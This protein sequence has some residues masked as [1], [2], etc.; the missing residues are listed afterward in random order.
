MTR[1]TEIKK[2]VSSSGVKPAL[3]GR[4]KK[5]RD[6]LISAGMDLLC[7][8]NFA[9]ISIIELTSA[10]GYSVGTFYSRFS[11]KESFFHAA[12]KAAV[13][14]FISA[15][16]EEF[17]KPS[18]QAASTEDIFRTMVDLSIDLLSTNIRGVVRGSI[19][20]AASD[21]DAWEPIRRCG[22]TLT[23]TLLNLLHPRFIQDATAMS[24]ESIKFG[25]QMLFGTLT[26]A[27]L[28]DNV[29]VKLAEPEMRDNLTRMLM[30]YTR[31][32]SE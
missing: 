22:E 11:D 23:K 13:A 28:N 1:S 32:K 24:E 18:W 17:S 19:A 6:D 29:N 26:Q 16:E 8:K 2:L 14:R 31:L 27:I 15:I 9:D 4:S 21:P 5:R 30:V 3:Q 25:M 10:C 7:E 12:Q 20:I